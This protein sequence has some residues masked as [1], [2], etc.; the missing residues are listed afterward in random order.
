MTHD[1]YKQAFEAAVGELAT[2]SKNRDTLLKEAGTLEDRM[3]KVRQGALGLVSL[4]DIDFQEVKDK[5]PD[6]FADQIDIR[7]GIT[8]AVRAVL[9][10]SSEMLTPIEIRER[11]FQINPAIAGQKS[12]L[13]SIHAIIRRLIDKWEVTYGVDNFERTA[14]GWIGSNDW[15]ER[16]VRWKFSD[17]DQVIEDIKNGKSKKKKE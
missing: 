5:Y 13:A 6:L 4:A 10:S 3:E 15:E 1:F 16:I 17:P 2:L 11:V 14:Y 9:S 7:M 8:D 12:P